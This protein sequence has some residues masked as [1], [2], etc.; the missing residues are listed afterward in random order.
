[1]PTTFVSDDFA[2][3]SSSSWGS[4]DTGGA[5]TLVGT[6]SDFNVSG[7]WGTISTPVNVT[8]RADL[9]ATDL[10][11][12]DWLFKFKVSAIPVGGNLAVYGYVRGVDSNN[13]LRATV[14]FK[15]TG[16]ITLALDKFIANS[17]TSNIQPGGAEYD[18]GI[19]PGAGT[20]YWLRVQ[21]AGANPTILRARLW[22]DGGSEP[23]TWPVSASVTDSQVQVA[24]S[25][26]IGSF[27]A[28]SITNAPIVVSFGNARGTQPDSVVLGTLNDF[29]LG[30]DYDDVFLDNPPAVTALAGVVASDSTI[31]AA[32]SVT[33]A[34]A[35]SSAT[36]ST[37][38]GSLTNTTPGVNLAG[39]VTAASTTT[40]ALTATA[41][42]AGQA[43]TVS[44]A[45]GALTVPIPLGGTIASTTTAAGTATVA[46]PPQTL[47]PITDSV[48]GAWTTD[49]GGTNLTAAIDEETPSDTD[50]IRSDLA[51]TNS[52]CRLKLATGNDPQSSTGHKI[53]WRA[54]KDST[55]PP[56]IN[57]T[58]TLRQG[59]GNTLGAGTQIATFTRTDIDTLTTFEETLTGGEADAITN[60]GDLYLELTANQV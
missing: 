45:T 47:A 35:G 56:Q 18:T 49:T 8:R 16:N 24:S 25:L 14:R 50:Y 57:V 48:D 9:N 55:G 22:A 23:S 10:L 43:D 36:A 51:P 54:G 4:A 60:Y 30:T 32:L 26:L 40:G 12:T 44:T 5:Y 37:A 29:L 21:A 39:T 59:G 6:A 3:T 41:P 34:L 38:T 19:T 52:A 42:L 7:G 1:M 58:I 13:S 2:R 11:E 15:P 28:S 31:T 33:A 17:L 53:K 20:V 46:P 27:G